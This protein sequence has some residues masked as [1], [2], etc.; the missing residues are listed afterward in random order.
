MGIMTTIATIG[1]AI[2][3]ADGASPVS[4]TCSADT[5]TIGIE[6]GQSMSPPCVRF[7]AFFIG[8]M[9]MFFQMT[10]AARMIAV[11]A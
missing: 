11:I 10:T 4:S 1:S 6:F 9:S 3:E 5:S 8:P 7:S 2:S